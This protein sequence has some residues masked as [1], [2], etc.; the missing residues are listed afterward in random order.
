M[1][2]PAWSLLTLEESRDA[3]VLG[4]SPSDDVMLEALSTAATLRCEAYCTRKLLSRAY[5]NEVYNG[6]G[7]WV[8]KLREYPVT[9]VTTVEFLISWAPDTWEVQVQGTYPLHIVEPIKDVIAYRNLHFPYGS[10]NVRV[11]YVAGLT[12]D[13]QLKTAAR[14][15]LLDLWKQ[16]DGQ[17]AGVASQSFGGQTTTYLN[18]AIPVSA[19]ALLDPYVRMAA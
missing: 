4:S 14:V 15:V 3:C 2:L 8:L 7:S 6:T 18:E 12:V 17:M 11:S 13:E 16:K 19:A 9:S 1:A 5:T 10:Q